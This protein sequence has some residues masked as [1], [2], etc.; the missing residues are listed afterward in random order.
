MNFLSYLLGIATGII[1]IVIIACITS[2]KQMKLENEIR[3][4]AIKDILKL[5]VKDKENNDGE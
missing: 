5:S 4:Q 2:Y 3:K 1:L